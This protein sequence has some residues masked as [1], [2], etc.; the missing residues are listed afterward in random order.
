MHLL[1]QRFR[2]GIALVTTLLVVC[3][4]A[5]ATGRKTGPELRSVSAESGG[6]LGDYIIGTKHEKTQILHHVTAHF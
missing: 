3:V 6:F 5:L 4:E 1:D 2:R